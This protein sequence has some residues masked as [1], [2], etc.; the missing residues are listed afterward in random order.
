MVVLIFKQSLV[1]DLECAQSVLL[2]LKKIRVVRIVYI[3]ATYAHLQREMIHSGIN[4]NLHMEINIQWNSVLHVEE[5]RLIMDIIRLQW[6]ILHLHF[7]LLKHVAHSG[8]VR[9]LEVVLA[10]N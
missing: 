5:A 2:R 7:T 1:I 4:T 8:I 9:D 10:L 3:T 6:M